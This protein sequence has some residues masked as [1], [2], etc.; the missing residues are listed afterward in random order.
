MI[1]A[2][3]D[4]GAKS[5]K[6]VI[7][8]DLEI[9][10]RGKV[11]TGFD[12]SRAVKESLDMA[13]KEAGLTRN[14]PA[15]VGGTGSGS[16]AV[17]DADVRVNDVKAMC[18]AAVYYFPNAR[19]VID[20]GAEESRAA[21]CDEKGNVV[22]FAI[23]EKCAAGAGAFIEAMSR[24][25]ETPLE[26]MGPLALSSDKQITINAQCTIFAES[27]VVGLIHAKTSKKDI[28]KAI[29]DAMAGR[30]VSMIRRIG[31]NPDVVMIGGL[32]YNPGI[33]AALTK[34]L[35][36]D[37]VRVPERPEYAAALGAALTAAERT[38]T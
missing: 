21:R 5:T 17:S 25:L 14:E 37:H 34:E 22:D 2:G 18:M 9:I 33:V 6:T 38:C 35:G 30:I 12:Q 11:P 24:A 31:V 19:T 20:V 1:V 26:E 23:N 3:V 8:K 29:H 15:A 32:A 7:L 10:G 36:V 28:S 27:E 16:E 13:L 4:C